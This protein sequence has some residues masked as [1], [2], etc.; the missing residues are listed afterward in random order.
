VPQVGR[1]FDGVEKRCRG[2]DRNTIIPSSRRRGSGR[3]IGQDYGTMQIGS[4]SHNTSC[5]A[6]PRRRPQIVLNA[7]NSGMVRPIQ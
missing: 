1:R 7:L 4:V 5:K 2:H 6:P 3:V